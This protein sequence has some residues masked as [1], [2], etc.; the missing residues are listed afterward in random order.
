[1]ETNETVHIQPCPIGPKVEKHTPPHNGH[2]T[3]KEVI[4]TQTITHV[5][6]EEKDRYRSSQQSHEKDKW[7][8]WITCP[9]A[10]GQ[11]CRQPGAGRLF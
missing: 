2:C 1:V 3:N 11:V 4:P 5:Q 10:L 6:K 9:A 8:K 7:V